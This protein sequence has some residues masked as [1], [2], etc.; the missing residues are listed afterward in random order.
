MSNELKLIL[1]K[2]LAYVSGVEDAQTVHFEDEPGPF[3]ALIISRH[4][5]L[6]DGNVIDQ[7]I[8]EGEI[9]LIPFIGALFH[10]S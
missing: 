8:S 9:D 5:S 2:G 1:V 4:S 6:M 10:S 7:D 3:E